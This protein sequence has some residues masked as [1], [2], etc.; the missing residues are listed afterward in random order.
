MFKVTQRHFPEVPID[1][2]WL[3][4]YLVV[5]DEKGKQAGSLVINNPVVLRLQGRSHKFLALSRSTY[6]FHG[7]DPTWDD[8]SARFR[9]WSRQPS[10][11]D[12]CGK[13][14]DSWEIY[15]DRQHYDARVWWPTMNVMLL[16]EPK[17]G[18]YERFAVGQI[19]V[20]AFEPL[21]IEEEII[22]G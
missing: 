11:L 18:V 22:L 7:K 9:H 14:E 10:N 12:E 4:P 2:D 6:L 17:D 16:S 8:E 21:A 5:L 15:F 3:N 19:H 20:T 1:T 13:N